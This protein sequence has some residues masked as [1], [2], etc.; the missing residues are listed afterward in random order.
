MLAAFLE[1]WSSVL[2]T[3]SPVPAWLLSPHL[4]GP[5]HLCGTHFPSAF[6]GIWQEYP[7]AWS[8]A[9]WL[10]YVCNLCKSP[11]IWGQITLLSCDPVDPT[12]LGLLE[13]PPNFH[14]HIWPLQHILCT[15]ANVVFLKPKSR[16]VINLAWTSSVPSHHSWNEFQSL[17]Y[18]L[19]ALHNLAESP[20]ALWGLIFP[21]SWPTVCS[22]EY[23]ALFCLRSVHV[24][25]PQPEILSFPS[26][27]TF[28]T[29]WFLFI[30]QVLD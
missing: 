11:V 7:L 9:L 1:N 17:Y 22:R 28:S 20:P 30:L 26:L 29:I 18:D 23:H 14:S 24:F 5:K 8:S 13:P 6:S 15:T 2:A 3:P 21:C 25:V 4:L 12:L 10:P 27:P 19:E 16:H